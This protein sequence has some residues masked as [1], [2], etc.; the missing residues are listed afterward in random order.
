MRFR[1][2]ILRVLL[3]IA[4]GAPSGAMPAAS[5]RLQ[6]SARILP[7]VA[8]RSAPLPAAVDV[9]SVAAAPTARTASHIEVFSNVGSFALHFAI[10][11]PAVV[12]VELEGLGA[13]GR[14]A[15]QGTTVQVRVAPGER[16]LA[17]RDIA[18]RIRYA[19]G[20]PPGLRPFPL[21]V[22]LQDH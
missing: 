9:E 17:R 19:P 18:Y 12:E 6:V 8:L 21:R 10:L 11:D 16:N 13:P 4:L 20:T 1:P 3:A 15:A 2:S 7:A 22:Y 5:Q 14:V